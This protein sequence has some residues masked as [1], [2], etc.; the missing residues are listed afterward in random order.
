MRSKRRRGQ[1]PVSRRGAR[2]PTKHSPRRRGDSGADEAPAIVGVGAS[3]GGLDAF[4]QLLRNLPLDTGMTFVL[5]QHLD[6]QHESALTQILSR[7]TSLPV[8]EITDN[9]PVRPNCVHVIPRGTNLSVTGGVLRLSKRSRMQARNRPID[10]FFESLAADQGERAIGVVLSGTGTDGTEGLEAI[11]AG[12]GITL[13]QDGSA[14]HDAMPRS[15]MAAGVVDLILPPSGIAR[16]LARIA[17][18]PHGAG[19]QLGRLAPEEGNR[20][21][22]VTRAEDESRL[23]DARERSVESSRRKILLLL[24]SHSGVDFSPYKLGT[25]ERRITRRIVLTRHDTLED[26]AG[27][28]RGNPEELDALYSDVLISVTSFF[29]NPGAFDALQREVLPGLFEKPYDEPVRVWVPGCSAGQEAYSLAITLMEA[30]ARLPRVRKFQIFATDLNEKLLDKARHGLYA[31][32][33]AEDVKRERL[34]RF[35]VEQDGGYRIIKRLR[36]TIVFARQNLVADPPFSRLDLISCRNLLIYLEPVLQRKVLSMFHYA[37]KPEGI[38]MLGAS[39]SISGFASLFGTVDKKHKIYVRKPAPT[40]ASHLSAGPKRSAGRAARGPLPRKQPATPQAPLAPRGEL[41]VQREADRTML[42]RFAPPGVLINENH[43]VVQFRG[44]TGAYLEPPVGGASFDVLRMARPGLML[45]LR[46]AIHQAIRK[47]KSVRRENVPVKGNGRMRRVDLE[48]IPLK[49]LDERCFLILF[50]EA[51]PDR[52]PSPDAAE[53]TPLS[54]K[55]EASGRIAELERELAE[56]REYLQSTQEQHESANEELQAAHEEVQSANEE[57]QSINEELETSKEEL[58]SANEEL[59][60]VNEEMS[61]RNVELNS[62]NNDL[63]NLQ[64]AMKMA[65]V[66]VGRDLTIRRFSPQAEAQFDLLATDVGRPIGKIRHHLVHASW[67]DVGSQVDLEE[68]AAEVLGSVREQEREVRDKGGH[69]YSLRVRPYLTLDNKVDGAVMVLVDIDDLKLTEL[70]I[71]AARDFA[72]N[73]VETVREPLLVLDQDLHVVRANRT[74]YN[75]FRV[76]PAETLGRLFYDLGNRQWDI[77]RLRELLEKILPEQRVMENFLVEHEFETIGRRIMLLNARQ[78]HDPLRKTRLILLAIE[79]ITAEENVRQLA[80][81]L[82]EA[83]RRKNEFLSM[84]AHELRG[85]LA[86]IRSALQVIRLTGA[87]EPIASAS[88]MME[89]QLGQMV[90][91]VD[92]LLDVGRISRGKVELRKERVDLASIVKHAVEAIRSQCEING[93]ELSVRC[94]PEQVHV[95]GDPIRL[96]QVVDNLLSNACKFTEPGGRIRL[97]V[98]REGEEAVVRVQDTGIGLAADQLSRIFEMFTQVDVPRERAQGGLGIGLTLVKTMLE[99]HGGTVEANSDGIGRGAEFVVRLPVLVDPSTPLA[100]P[101]D[102]PTAQARRRVLIVDDSRDTT[103]SMAML[104]ELNGHEVRTAHDGLEAV[105]TAGIFRP[106]VVLLDI[107]LPAL[108]GFDA[109]RRIREQP[110]GRTIV[111]V[112]LTGLGQEEDRARSKEAGFDAHIVKPVDYD[113][114]MKLLASLPGAPG[115]PSRQSRAT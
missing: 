99:L 55:K 81:G 14:A 19:R 11:K 68:M 75:A 43:D 15:A 57:L 30:S 4:T 92:D 9:Q 8:C 72:E 25:I 46:S 32:S 94:T 101:G 73:T 35:F 27:F 78:V 90:R 29:R 28:L 5:V 74:F 10:L 38:L 37:L 58:E 113:A 1:P 76:S 2:V 7:V 95:D 54:G 31:K 41:S 36:E 33:L 51:A 49:N 89:R 80:A 47:K 18:H 42:S 93:L 67:D 104:L 56:T 13:A 100:P 106:D 12:G 84:L 79:D 71:A 82:A 53:A 16:E 96:A 70:A 21:E 111:L 108:N 112:A 44:S 103:D 20:S 114:L 60:T 22:A 17:R 23:P 65:I 102:E 69:W 26:Y 63:A 98:E 77:P 45:P 24:R 3:A 59:T 40:P 50:G 86:P 64:N 39:E 88:A 34:Q 66:L 107:G 87:S 110:W 83:D 91:L 6:P 62:L 52:A 48:V 61:N 115:R 97:T 85:P 109:C 105:E